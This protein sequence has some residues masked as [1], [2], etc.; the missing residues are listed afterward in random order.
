M[1]G[2]EYLFVK[3]KGRFIPL[4]R[5]IAEMGKDD[6]NLEMDDDLKSV[7]Q[8][9][10]SSRPFQAYSRGIPTKEE[11]ELF[12]EV[13]RLLDVEMDIVRMSRTRESVMAVQI[14]CNLHKLKY[15]HFTHGIH[16]LKCANITHRDRTTILN[17]KNK[18][19][20]RIVV[21]WKFK[22]KYEQIKKELL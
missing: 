12:E 9:G 7:Y 6:V 21:D 3:Y 16:V 18:F 19:E 1:N 10:I 11:E 22:E 5:F 20:T 14:F 15:P 4:N 8:R 17:A 2:M 13:C